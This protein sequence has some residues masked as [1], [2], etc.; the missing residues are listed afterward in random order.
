MECKVGI[1]K[2]G[3]CYIL[4]VKSETEKFK[5][6]SFTIIS[7]DK[8]FLNK[9]KNVHYPYAKLCKILMR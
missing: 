9:S 8:I 3:G 4:A 1:Y 5:T 6:V 7:R 2:I